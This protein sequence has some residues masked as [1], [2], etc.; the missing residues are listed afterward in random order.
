MKQGD[1]EWLA[2]KAGKIS[3]SRFK[4]VLALNKRNGKPNKP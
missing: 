4:D 1:A 3:G 2:I